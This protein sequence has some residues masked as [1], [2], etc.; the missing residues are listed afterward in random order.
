MSR[1]KIPDRIQLQVRERAN[2]LCEYCHANERWQYVRFTVDHVI[3]VSLGGQDNLENLTLACFHCNRHKTSRLTAIEPESQTEVPLF[4][5]RQD[6]WQEH[7]IWSMDGLS[8]VGISPTG[9]ATVVA[10]LLNRERVIPIRAADR[11]IGRH[12][13]IDDPIQTSQSLT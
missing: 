9:K 3:P 2:Y 8:I 12:P 10:L 1:N 5:P 11:E 7:F 4:N 13:P 6:S